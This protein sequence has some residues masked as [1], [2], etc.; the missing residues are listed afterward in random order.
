M[1]LQEA[2]ET[3]AKKYQHSSWNNMILAFIK[4]DLPGLNLAE[5]NEATNQAAELYARSKWDE[6][7]NEMK[8][9]CD[10]E[11]LLLTGTHSE[12]PKPEFKP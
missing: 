12:A 6:A 4:D 10:A 8:G 11:I 2:K 9:I 7:C 1:T 5:I 3:I